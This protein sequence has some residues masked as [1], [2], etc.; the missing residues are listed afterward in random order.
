MEPQLIGRD[1]E[2][3]EISAFLS[4]TS[5]LPA[6]LAITGD[7]GI[8]KTMVWQN[9]LRVAGRSA[10]VLS[11]QPTFAE[12][13]L[14]FSVLDDLF[15]DVPG[16]VLQALPG[17]RRQAVEVALLRDVSVS[18]PRSGRLETGRPPPGR[19]A[20]ARGILDALRI[21]AGDAPLVLAVDDAHWLD[22]PSAHVLEFCLRRLER[23]PVLILLTFR[24]KDTAFPLGLDRA[25]S[26]D[27]LGRVH[28]GPLTLGAIGEIVR[29]RMGA[30]L[31]RYAL[32]RLYDACGGNPFY[33]LEC[34]RVLIDHPYMSLTNEPLPL[35]KS[36]DGLVLRRVRRLPPEVR[37]VGR[38]VAASFDRRERLI[39]AA[40]GCG[41]S[42]ANA[43]G[44]KAKRLSVGSACGCAV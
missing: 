28:L 44:F 2:V 9:T 34:A 11:C 21:L 10:R 32:T 4:A 7:A 15:G 42:W 39:R 16:E 8:G 43:S 1:A 20:L 35:P 24:D 26:P 19:R 23:E 14:A 29:S 5:D 36:L 38:L 22:R 30:V 37:R 25:L 17:P 3:A 27:R 40:C 41:E 6:A 33:A 12:R 13:P 31:P 18:R